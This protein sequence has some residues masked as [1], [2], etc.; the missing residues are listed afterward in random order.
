M[1]VTVGGAEPEPLIL[2][3]AAMHRPGLAFCI[4]LLVLGRH[5]GARSRNVLLIVGECRRPWH[6][7]LLLP[8]CGHSALPRHWPVLTPAR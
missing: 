4:V 7:H 1:H 5:C 3:R 2:T 8:R 6:G